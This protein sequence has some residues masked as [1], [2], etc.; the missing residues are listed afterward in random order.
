VI[1]GS[2]SNFGGRSVVG[3]RGGIGFG[4]HRGGNVFISARPFHHPRGFSVFPYRYS[5]SYVYPYVV[6]PAYPLSYY[7]AYDYAAAPVQP[8][9]GYQY[10]YASG[11]DNYPPEMGLAEQ[12]RQQNVGVYAQPRAA[13]PQ[14]APQPQAAPQPDRAMPPTVLI[15]RDGKRTEVRNYAIVGQTLW[16][17][18]ERVANKVPLGQLDLDATR[19]ANEERG[20][21]F[22]V[23]QQ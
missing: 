12:M 2:V 17:F 23:P 4:G 7:D 3:F 6:Y 1:V 22:V 11:G 18:S 8:A 21:D 15:Y 14:P 5:S 20:M 9:Y 13:T 10:E 16:T 19:K